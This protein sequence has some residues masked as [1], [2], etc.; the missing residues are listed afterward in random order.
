MSNNSQDLDIIVQTPKDIIDKL[1]TILGWK[2]N[3]IDTIKYI[4]QLSIS[5]DISL[6]A[7]CTTLT[8][9]QP[10]YSMFT[11]QP[12]IFFQDATEGATIPVSNVEANCQINI[13]GKITKPPKSKSR[14]ISNLSCELG[15]NYYPGQKIIVKL[16]SM[17]GQ[18]IQKQE[19]QVTS[20]R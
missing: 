14:F 18:L 6:E 16:E 19:I 13:D 12:T 1:N 11:V 9:S 4:P 3:I 2:K 5:D 10:P 15:R 20:T 7:L 8:N 17:Y